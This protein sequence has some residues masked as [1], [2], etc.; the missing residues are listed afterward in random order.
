[1][2]ISN[3]DHLKTISEAPRVVGGLS[4]FR[5]Y[6]LK[7]KF[8]LLKEMYPEYTVYSTSASWEADDGSKADV[9]TAAGY[10]QTEDANFAYASSTVASSYSSP[11]LS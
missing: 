9:F 4:L 3:L 10:S 1:M 2:N 6:S 8:L 5:S 7:E 11:L